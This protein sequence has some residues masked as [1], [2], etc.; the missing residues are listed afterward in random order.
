MKFEDPI[1]DEDRPQARTIALAPYPEARK[2]ATK[3]DQAVRCF[4]LFQEIVGSIR[5]IRAR[6]EI[7]SKT[8]TPVVIGVS[9]ENEAVLQQQ[10]SSFKNFTQSEVSLKPFPLTPTVSTAV[11][12]LPTQNGFIEVH[13]LLKGAIT[14]EK[15]TARIE[16]EIDKA[17]KNLAAVDKKLSG[18]D[19][20]QRAP[21]N[22]VEETLQQKNQ[23]QS[24]LIALGEAKTFA[25]TL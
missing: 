2:D 6:Y 9:P 18:K 4:E 25:E 23:L 10:M 22:V 17:L 20:L 1:T 8:I 5:T 3:D 12:I 15:E 11:D 14:R 13:V 19:F 21:T 16:R 7:D 24:T